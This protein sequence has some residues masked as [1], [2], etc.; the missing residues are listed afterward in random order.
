MPAAP[1]RRSLTALFLGLF[2]TFAAPAPAA[3]PEGEPAAPVEQLHATLL[4]TMQQAEKLGFDGR[5][6]KVEP[7]LAATFDFATI[8]R[9]VTGRYW[10]GLDDSQRQA[11]VERF[12]R[13]SAATYAARF[14]S[15]AGETFRTVGSSEERGYRLIRTELVKTDGTAVSLA[16]AVAPSAA[17]WRIVN[18]I[19]DGVSDLSLKRADY[20]S[21]LKDG[22]M[23]ALL[24]RLDRQ[25][26][27]Y[28]AEATQ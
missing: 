25:I 4:E 3:E 9:V 27:D 1:L 8:A 26:A 13:L 11:F 16:Y 23:E 24:G 10:R 5:N 15:Y 21:I 19:A 17:G 20:T 12:A 18:V 22:G 6:A 7:V 2:A 28:R 14:D